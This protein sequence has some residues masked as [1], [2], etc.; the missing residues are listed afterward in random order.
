MSCGNG[1]LACDL[2]KKRIC[3]PHFFLQKPRG[4]VLA[5][6]FQRVGAN[7]FGE[8]RG[9]MRGSCALGAHL[10]EFHRN[11]ATGTLPRRFRTGEAGA[12]DADR[13]HVDGP[14]LSFVTV[15]RSRSNFHYRLVAEAEKKAGLL[16]SG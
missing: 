14:E 5:V 10:E 6:G 9:L 2:E 13:C 7:E 3:A 8:I 4:C 12:D 11:A 1:S 15:R 16:R